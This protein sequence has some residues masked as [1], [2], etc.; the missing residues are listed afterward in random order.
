MADK[1]VNVTITCGTRAGGKSLTRGKVY[2]LS[3]VDA[4]L[5]VSSQRGVYGGT[6]K[7]AAAK[8]D[9]K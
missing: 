9:E 6:L 5:V 7:K 8:K 2:A 4:K 1:K 3:A